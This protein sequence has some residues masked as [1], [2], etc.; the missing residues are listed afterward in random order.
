MVQLTSQDYWSVAPVATGVNRAGGLIPP[1]PDTSAAGDVTM[2]REP[3][4]MI[5]K[6]L[7][8]GVALTGAVQ[9]APVVE[10]DD[11]RCDDLWKEWSGSTGARG[12]LRSDCFCP[13]FRRLL[14]KSGDSLSLFPVPLYSSMKIKKSMFQVTHLLDGSFGGEFVPFTCIKHIFR[15]GR[16]KE[17][18]NN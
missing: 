13:Y 17:C 6:P 12:E 10:F 2:V 7:P 8:L 11:G 1:F 4:V 15:K 16:T 18:F 3:G 5:V 14:G 9:E